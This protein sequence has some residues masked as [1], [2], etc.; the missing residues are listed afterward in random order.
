M[1]VIRSLRKQR[2]E[3]LKDKQKTHRDHF[4]SLRF[5]ITAASI[6]F[7]GKTL[8]T[9][10][11]IAVSLVSAMALSLLAGCG[12]YVQPTAHP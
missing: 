7:S 12:T 1:D 4:L 5:T 11:Y 6:P 9:D 10:N 3:E 2:T 8:V